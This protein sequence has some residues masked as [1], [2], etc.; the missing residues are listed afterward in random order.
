MK[1]NIVLTSAR[2]PYD[3]DHLPTEVIFALFFFSSAATIPLS[4]VPYKLLFLRQALAA[5]RC[6]PPTP[7]SGVVL[8]DDDEDSDGTEEAPHALEDSDVQEEEAT[9]DDAFIRSRRRKQVH[10]DLITSAE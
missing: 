10:D 3:S 7:E 9:E 2:P 5:A 6:Y 8:E 4:V 1:D